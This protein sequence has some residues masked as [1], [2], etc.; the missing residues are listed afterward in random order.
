MLHNTSH[1]LI[2]FYRLKIHAYAG[3]NQ[4]NYDSSTF[5]SILYYT[6]H[7]LV[8]MPD[9]KFY[10]HRHRLHHALI[11]ERDGGKK[12]REG[13]SYGR[14]RLSVLANHIGFDQW[15]YTVYLH[16]ATRMVLPRGAETICSMTATDTQDPAM[17]PHMRSTNLYC[18]HYVSW[19][20][21]CM[22]QEKRQAKRDSN[23]TNRDI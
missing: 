23:S 15:T 13:A 17:H 20:A 8:T 1:V 3:I 2:H 14:G 9:H 5:F 6:C 4:Y 10:A 7:T 18:L 16:A 22:Y 12:E 11:D 19:Q 21:T